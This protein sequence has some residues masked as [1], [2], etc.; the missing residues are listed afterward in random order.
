MPTEPAVTHEDLRQAWQR[1]RWWEPV[2][3]ILAVVAI[4][5][6][7][8]QLDLGAHSPAARICW[9]LLPLPVLVPAVWSFVRS[10]RSKSE[11]ERQILYAAGKKALFVTTIGL[12]VLGQID[13]ALSLGGS[14][15]RYRDLWF[16]PI[17]AYFLFGVLET[18]RYTRG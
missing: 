4:R 17:F 12:L 18:K 16:I 11:L 10:E 7:Q 1:L 15:W 13:T 9:A 5:Y 8:H 3:W 2:T 6:S 14:A